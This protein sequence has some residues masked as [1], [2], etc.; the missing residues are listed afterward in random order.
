M[1]EL[2]PPDKICNSL[3]DWIAAPSGADFPEPLFKEIY[4]DSSFSR[5]I[6]RPP[7]RYPNTLEG[8]YVGVIPNG[9]VWGLNGA[10]ITPDQKLIWDV[11]YE[12]VKPRSNHSIFK[13]K[14]LPAVSHVFKN[15]ADLTH[16]VGR[17][18]YHW[19]YEVIPR[20]HL[21]H[22]S[23]IKADYFIVKSEP[24]H[25]QFQTETLHKLGITAEQLIKTHTGFHIQAENLVV[26]SQPKFATEWGWRF[27]RKTFLPKNKLRLSTKKRIYI[28]RK[29]S[30]RI[31][32]ENEVMDVLTQYGFSKVELENLTVQEQAQLF[33]T[34]E[35]IVGAHGAGLANLTFCQPGTK[36]LEIFAPSYITSLYW[37]ISSLGDLKHYYFIGK[38][39]KRDPA[40]P[41][42]KWSGLDDITIN[43]REF[44]VFVQK[45]VR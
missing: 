29:W 38:V 12:M 15:A 26:P 2:L 19:M 34:A 28:S 43:I 10:I 4:P 24:D 25:L 37:V 18:Y 5:R 36:V 1:S 9:R 14:K 22:K 40:L 21:M 30:R 20:I 8:G 7:A 23:G 3:K 45:M 17:N 6:K 13:E 35:V 39:S 42:H 11:S 16:I 32:N 31:T 33:S 27:L 41:D 44:A